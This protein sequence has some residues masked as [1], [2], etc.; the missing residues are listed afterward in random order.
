VATAGGLLFI[1]A[2]SD[3]AFSRV[4][5][6]DGKLLWE[7]KLR[8][9]AEANPI[10]YL[11]KNGKAVRGDDANDTLVAFALPC[12]TWQPARPAAPT[13]TS[14]CRR[15]FAMPALAQAA[16]LSPPGAPLTATRADGDFAE[17]DGTPP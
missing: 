11:G 1:G 7:T 16:S 10:T 3:A 2:S 14:I 17:L 6:E 8:R 13:L 15:L 5:I 12:R 9:V 4:R